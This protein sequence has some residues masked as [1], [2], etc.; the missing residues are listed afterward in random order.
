MFRKWQCSRCLEAQDL[1][2]LRQSRGACAVPAVKK[3]VSGL[4][5]FIL[6]GRNLILFRFH[7]AK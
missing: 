2:D 1:R 3:Q 5:N 6:H 7:N 4:E